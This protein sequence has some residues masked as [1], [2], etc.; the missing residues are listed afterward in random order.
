MCVYILHIPPALPGPRIP[1]S[2]RICLVRK[3]ERGREGGREG[4]REGGKE[5]E[6]ERVELKSS[7]THWRNWVE[8]RMR[9]NVRRTRRRRKCPWK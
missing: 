7:K 8:S 9:G 2:L 6:R 1:T 4:R 5:G 3:Q